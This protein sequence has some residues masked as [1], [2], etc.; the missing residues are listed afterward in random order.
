[1]SNEI[2]QEG[3]YYHDLEKVAQILELI[4]KGIESHR[5]GHFL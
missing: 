1:M 5:V 4:L 2:N 3:F